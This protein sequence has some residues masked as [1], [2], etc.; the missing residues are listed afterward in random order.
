MGEV[1][2]FDPILLGLSQKESRAV[3]CFL[4]LA[5]CDALGASTEFTP[6]KKDR[7]DLV[8]S[9][10]EDVKKQIAKGALD[11]RSGKIGIWTDDC[12]MA[13]CMADSLLLQGFKFDPV[14]TR[15]MFHMWLEHGLGNGGRPHSIGL[16]GNISI[17][18]S[19]F[20]K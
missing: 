6:Y 2:C 14:H 12:S 17:S 1:K 20:T 10:F 4:G 16:G 9:D 3:A 15:Y 18:M 11:S 7:R 8:K 19:E 5:I 13:L